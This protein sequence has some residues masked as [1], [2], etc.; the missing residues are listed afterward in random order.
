MYSLSLL[1]KRFFVPHDTQEISV[2]L[3]PSKILKY[4]MIAILF[5]R[6]KIYFDVM[7]R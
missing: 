2:L 7:H 6:K 5:F 4:L 3:F 1:P